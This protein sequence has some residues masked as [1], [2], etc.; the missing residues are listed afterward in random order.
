M[1]LYIYKDG[2]CDP[3]RKIGVARQFSSAKDLEEYGKLFVASLNPVFLKNYRIFIA[4]DEVQF[5]DIDNFVL[6][7]ETLSLNI[8][9]K[10]QEIDIFS[11]A[12]EVNE[13]FKRM[14]KH[15]TERL[16]LAKKMAAQTNERLADRV[17]LNLEDK[18][19]AP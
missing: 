3:A 11:I 6:M 12:K 1:I 4:N 14:D 5:A 17:Q 10:F 13:K 2:L 15:R 19:K 18:E 8:M 16:A 9:S 7:N